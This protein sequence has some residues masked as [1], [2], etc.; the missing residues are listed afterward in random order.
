ME[1]VDNGQN[2]RWTMDMY[3]QLNW[4]LNVYR[5][6]QTDNEQWTRM[7]S[8]SGVYVCIAK[9]GNPPSIMKRFKVRVMCK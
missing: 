6:K 5:K 2:G 8:E 3:V 9:N 1:K 4:S 7:F